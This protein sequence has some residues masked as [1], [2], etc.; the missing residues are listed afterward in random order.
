M[1]ATAWCEFASIGLRQPPSH[2]SL[3]LVLE[4]IAQYGCFQWGWLR[5]LFGFPPTSAHY[6]PPQPTSH[7][8][9]STRAD[10]SCKVSLQLY[11]VLSC[12]LCQDSCLFRFIGSPCCSSPIL[13]TP[14]SNMF[15]VIPH[16]T[17][18]SNKMISAEAEVSSTFHPHTIT[19]HPGA[20][21]EAFASGGRPR[22]CRGIRIFVGGER[23]YGS[24]LFCVTCMWI[25]GCCVSFHDYFLIIFV[26]LLLDGNGG[27]THY[28]RSGWCKAIV[29][30][31]QSAWLCVGVPGD[32]MS[33]KIDPL[34][35]H[36][37]QFQMCNVHFYGFGW[38]FSSA[39]RFTKVC[40]CRYLEDQSIVNG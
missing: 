25:F 22:H 9:W 23:I 31:W 12:F 35:L 5:W 38:M 36:P 24:G 33:T 27:P 30:G 15:L 6:C 2:Y 7:L 29:K 16:V 37:Q 18:S 8:P 19:H 32:V 34:R 13:F 1:F 4:E 20:T 40:L 3:T 10:I 28:I 26:R 39:N 17:F 14:R 11:Q 21:V